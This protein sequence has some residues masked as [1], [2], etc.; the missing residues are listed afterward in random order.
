MPIRHLIT[1]IAYKMNWSIVRVAEWLLAR[2]YEQYATAYKEEDSKFYEI[3]D[4]AEPL[5]IATRYLLT[6]ILNIGYGALCFEGKSEANKY[7]Y[8]AYYKMDDINN[9][10]ILDR[11]DLDFNRICD[12]SYSTDANGYVKAINHNL[13]DD[14]KNTADTDSVEQLL[15]DAKLEMEMLK[16]AH[17]TGSFMMGELAIGHAKPKT[18]EEL[19]EELATANNELEQL[20]KDIP[21]LRQQTYTLADDKELSTRSQNLAAKIILALLDIA[22]L[23]RDSLPYQYDDLRSSNRI[24]HDQIKANGMNVGH[25]K[26]GYWLNLAIN[27]ATDE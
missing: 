3:N 14:V 1:F 15:A 21:Q 19:I 20:K 11:L 24:I 27:Q 26:I 13:I 25:Q 2:D 22:E 9:H 10:H 18:N 6:Q 8:K 23:D 16:Q 5:D 17:S 7:F 12:F 4:M